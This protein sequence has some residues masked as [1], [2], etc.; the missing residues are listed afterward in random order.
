MKASTHVTNA[1]QMEGYERIHFINASV[2]Q[3]DIFQAEVNFRLSP[4]LHISN[5][6]VKI[7]QVEL[8]LQDGKGYRSYPLGEKLIPYRFNAIGERFISIRLIRTNYE[9]GHC[10]KRN[11]FG[12]WP[13]SAYFPYLTHPS[14]S[15]IG[16]G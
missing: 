11:L 13:V 5:N 1:R 9:T 4:S 3:E 12:R 8:D 14:A 15:T 6:N 2:L 10:P 7:K 16:S